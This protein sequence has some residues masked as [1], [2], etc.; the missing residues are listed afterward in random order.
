MPQGLNVRNAV[1]CA[2]DG[3]L[4]GIFALNYV[5]HPTIPP[6]ISALVGNRVAPV[7]C[8]RDFNVIPAMLRQKF[9]LPVEKMDFPAV[10]RRT[11][12]SDPD[13]LH[14]PRLTAVLCREG[15][16]PFSEAVVGAKRL[17]LAVYLSTALSI[18]GSLVGLLLAFYLTFVGAWQSITP[19]QMTIFLLAWTVPTFLISG[20]VNRY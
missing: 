13:L 20:W 19:A 9:K 12:L 4:A 3:E 18:V 2:I 8:T 6:A 7:L 5:M 11:E 16:G 14:S 10:E 1:F 15:L 17:R